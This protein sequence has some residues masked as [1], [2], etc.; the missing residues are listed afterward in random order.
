MVTIENRFITF[1]K[2]NLKKNINRF[3][4]SYNQTLVLWDSRYIYEDVDTFEL[5]D[6]YD[7]KKEYIVHDIKKIADTDA[8]KRFCDTPYFTLN[9]EYDR[10]NYKILV[11]PFLFKHEEAENIQKIMSQ[12][13]IHFHTNEKMSAFIEGKLFNRPDRLF[14]FNFINNKEY[15]VHVYEVE[16]TGKRGDMLFYVFQDI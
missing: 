15:V 2:E 1:I 16:E 12:I 4:Y 10:N 6:N 13:K 11:N 8:F 3:E 14:S 5:F 9:I 7:N